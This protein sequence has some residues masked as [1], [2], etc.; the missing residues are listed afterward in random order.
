MDQYPC[1]LAGSAMQ[2]SAGGR[3]AAMPRYIRTVVMAAAICSLR[4]IA[5]E[6]WEIVLQVTTRAAPAA[7]R[8][9]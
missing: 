8:S 2:E 7:S 3:C 1:N 5:L 9:S 4:S 6:G